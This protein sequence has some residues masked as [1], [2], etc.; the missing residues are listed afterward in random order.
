MELNNEDAWEGAPDRADI[1]LAAGV[2]GFRILAVAA[3]RGR[4]VAL[5]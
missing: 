2:P 5:V 3:A 1:L 4:P